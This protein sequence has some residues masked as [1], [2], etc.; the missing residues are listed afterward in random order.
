MSNTST[1]NEN[2]QAT[3]TQKL[4][5]SVIEKN[6]GE[7]ILLT[8]GTK[9]ID[10]SESEDNVV[11]HTEKKNEWLDLLGSGA[12]MK[13]IITEGK[14]DTRPQRSEK[15]IINYC[16]L[17]EDG[18]VVDSTDNFKLN[19][20]ESDVISGLDVALGLMNVGEK[21]KLKIEPRLAFG[22]KGLPP[23]ILPDTV[24]IYDVELVLV[25][26]ED[27]IENLSVEQRK[28][29]GNQKRERGNWWYSRGDNNIAIQCYRRALD[30]LDEVEGGI[31]LPENKTTEVTD[32]DL[33]SLLED[34]ISVYN[35][36]AAAQIKME[37]FDAALSSL[38]IVLRCQP[39]NVKAHFRKAKVYV[40]KNDLPTAMRCLQKAKE[41]APNDIE[42]QKEINAVA[43]ILEK[44]KVSERELA[45]RMF[46]PP[47]KTDKT[48]SKRHTGKSKLGLW[49]TLGAT[50]AVGVA[51]IAAYRFKYT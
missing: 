7:N 17:L 39:N 16:C 31:I 35:N 34:R 3:E 20:G 18:T 37:M 42:I 25:E 1:F 28:C 33:Q 41:L 15:C 44:Q 46:N 45:K 22:S 12:V 51:G 23:K 30:Y 8:N 6:E 48:D 43:K 14:P 4:T 49:A 24:V 38:Q 36:M 13:K 29:I 27:E 19:L 5:E 2:E 26:P 32:S 11:E 21:C 40:G 10:A 50:V 47:K 9:E